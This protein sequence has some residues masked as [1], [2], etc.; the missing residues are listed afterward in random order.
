MLRSRSSLLHPRSWVFGCALLS[1]AACGPAPEGEDLGTE[2]IS[3]EISVSTGCNPAPDQAAVFTGT[4]YTGK[5]ALLFPA[6]YPTSGSKGF[7]VGNDDIS[8]AIVGSQVLLDLYQD[9]NFGGSNVS[10]GAG[11]HPSLG[12]FNNKASSAIV[13]C[14]YIPPPGPSIPPPSNLPGPGIPTRGRTPVFVPPSPAPVPV[15][16]P[17]GSRAPVPVLPPPGSRA[18]TPVPGPP[19]SRAPTPAPGACG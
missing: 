2:N 18:P 13:D 11:G 17:P 8:S 19:G 6:W 10:L 16:P 7:G 5:C 12:S 4:N 15:G 9:K 3:A 14:A 1:A